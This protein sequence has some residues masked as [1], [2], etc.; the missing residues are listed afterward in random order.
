[1]ERIMAWYKYQWE[2]PTRCLVN[3]RTVWTKRGFHQ[4][5]KRALSRLHLIRWLGSGKDPKTTPPDRRRCRIDG[6]SS[7]LPRVL[8]AMVNNADRCHSI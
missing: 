7:I 6:A 8:E 2:N 3:P 5:P 4:M 1:M